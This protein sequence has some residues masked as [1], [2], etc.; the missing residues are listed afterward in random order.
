MMFD[1]SFLVAPGVYLKGLR[2]MPEEPPVRS[3]RTEKAALTRHEWR[4]I[5][6]IMAMLFMMVILGLGYDR[7]VAAAGS[8]RAQQL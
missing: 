6:A 7:F 1:Q 2:Y 4:S 5:A 8:P 3:N